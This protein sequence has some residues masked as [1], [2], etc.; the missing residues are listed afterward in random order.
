MQQ[1]QQQLGSRQAL[2][3]LV[4]VLDSPSTL[5]QQDQILNI[6]K[7]NPPFMAAFIKQRQVSQLYIFK[8]KLFDLYIV[9]F[10]NS[11]FSLKNISK[12]SPNLS[13]LFN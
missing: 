13:N 6:L 11:L 2:Q 10:E 5:E 9:Y 7:N 4:Q 12:L 1:S 3:Q 8:M